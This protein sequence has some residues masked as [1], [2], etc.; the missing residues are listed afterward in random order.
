MTTL[1]SNSK[2]YIDLNQKIIC[3]ILGK[4]KK[5][6]IFLWLKQTQNLYI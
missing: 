3:I 1:Q 2:I 6:N 5:K 4:E